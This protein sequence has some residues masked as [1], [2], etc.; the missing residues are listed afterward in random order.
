MDTNIDGG[1]LNIVDDYIKL[2]RIQQSYSKQE[3]PLEN[4]R[5]LREG[6][7]GTIYGFNIDSEVFN[8]L[9]SLNGDYSIDIESVNYPCEIVNLSEN[10]IEIKI[11]DY[12]KNIVKCLF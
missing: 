4:G 2:K 5:I 12:N 6:K 1:L 7:T 9:D 10:Q 3:I 11:N 8:K